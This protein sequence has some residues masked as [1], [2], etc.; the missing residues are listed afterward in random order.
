M[1]RTSILLVLLAGPHAAAVNPRVEY[2]FGVL[3]ESRGAEESAAVH[4][5]NARLADPSARPLVER[6]V[7]RLLAANDRA[8]AIRLFRELAAAR[9]DDL[10][11]QLAYAD[12]LA[13]EG[14]GDALATRL[15]VE[16][17]DASLAK[18]P[19]DPEI[20]RRLCSLD[21]S[22][23]A[24]LLEMLAADD[25]A[26]V[27]LYA[28]L[29]KSLPDDE[30]DSV[31]AETD[32]RFFAAIEAHPENPVLA[33]GASEHFRNTKRLDQAIKV[34]QRHTGSAPWSLDLRVRLGVLHFSAKQ[35]AEG[36]TVLKEVL[37]IHPRHALAHQSL[38]KFYQLR[39]QPGPAAYHSGELLKIRGGSPSEFTKLADAF[40]TSG[41][42]REARI[43]L[44]KA[45]FNH[46]DDPDLRMKLAIATHR[47]PETRAR[48]ARMFRE[49]E[50]AAPDGKVSDPAFLTASAE[51]LI[52]SGQGK[53]GEERLRAAIRAYPPD[54]KKETAA[55]LRRLAALWIAEN[56]NAE[57]ARALNLRADSLDPKP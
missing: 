40:L 36:E 49:A 11:T 50:A 33:R 30:G 9:P 53:A 7:T 13:N 57:A 16:T 21:R 34:L 54:A 10:A 12:F 45:V 24:G 56:R 22:R 52:E 29:A 8:G 1:F 39:N 3:D 28:T 46:P 20:I 35:D 26:A 43:L 48:A 47:D 31:S 32:R 38:A 4:F 15:A 14:R 23:T 19:G 42:A 25:P 55:A 27:M 41:K 37:A 2:A 17:L 44:E 6:S 51:A 18:H 5:E